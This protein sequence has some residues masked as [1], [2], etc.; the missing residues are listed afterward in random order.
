MNGLVIM[1]PGL[2][3]SACLRKP[4]KTSVQYTRLARRPK[5][6]QVQDISGEYLQVECQESIRLEKKTGT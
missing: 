1:I 6:R 4:A 5:S 3:C 2:V